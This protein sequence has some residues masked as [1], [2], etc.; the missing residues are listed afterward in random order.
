MQETTVPRHAR[1]FALTLR[2]YMIVVAYAAV[3]FAVNTPLL[4]MPGRDHTREAHWSV[5]LLSPWVLGGLVAAFD[6]PGPLR[7]WTVVVLLFLFFPALAVGLDLTLALQ[8]WRTGTWLAPWAALVFNLA[9]VGPTLIFFRRMAPR[10]CPACGR[11]TVI[12]LLRI[13]DQSRRVQRTYACS[14]CGRLFWR[15]CRGGWQVERRRTWLSRP[16][17]LDLSDS[18]ALTASASDSASSPP[19]HLPPCNSPNA[20]SGER[21]SVASSPSPT[22]MGRPTDGCRA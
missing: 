11:T 15:D 6:R 10:R 19:S 22:T 20:G 9:V 5:L 3:I 13:A 1:P 16:E 21:A 2:R 17:P 18:E 8:G 4:D 12:P 14:A 7:N